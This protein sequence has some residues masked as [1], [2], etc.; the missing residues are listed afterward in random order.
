MVAATW[1][2]ARRE[3]LTGTDVAAIAG[4][5]SRIPGSYK[6]EL[7]VWLHKAGYSLP[8]RGEPGKLRLGN[9]LEGVVAQV[10]AHDL[11]RR[12]R[13]AAAS[14]QLWGDENILL[15]PSAD[16]RD[17]VLVTD[18]VLPFGGT[19]DFLIMPA[20]DAPA[21]GWGVL[22]VKTGGLN[23]LPL[24]NKGVPL[25]HRIQAMWYAGLLGLSWYAVAALIGGQHLFLR[26]FEVNPQ[27][28]AWLRARAAAWWKRYVEGNETPPCAAEDL[29]T[30]R[31]LY[32]EGSGG[33]VEL[34]PRWEVVWNRAVALRGAANDAIL[35]HDALRA[36]VLMA[37][38]TAEEARVAG[39]DVGWTR[40]VDDNGNRTLRS[41]RWK[42]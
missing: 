3:V 6:T 21:R 30:V 28:L 10:Y 14:D 7:Q 31:D 34:E 2:E 27:E 41:K 33:R 38:G 26:E 1:E 29:E 11:K 16:G 23:M 5:P 35:E 15:L 17:R 8:F 13:G 40:Y 42:Q 9:L 20:D 39:T 18:P 37:M 25:G 32:P 36:Q 22:E 24:W 4:P 12:L 19:P